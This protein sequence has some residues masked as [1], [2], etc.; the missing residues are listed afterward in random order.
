[1]MVVIPDNYHEFKDGT[2]MPAPYVSGVVALML[3]ANP[4][5]TPEQVRQIIVNTA[6]G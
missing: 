2:S 3:S 5:L 1:M 6:V 4:Y